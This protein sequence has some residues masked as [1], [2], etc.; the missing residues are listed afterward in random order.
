MARQG[1]K[2]LTLLTL[3]VSINSNAIT[4]DHAAE[5]TTPERTP[6]APAR[7][8]PG[9][10]ISSISSPPCT[11][12]TR[13]YAS[14]FD[15][16][17]DAAAPLLSECALGGL[18]NF[19]VIE[20]FDPFGK[21]LDAIKGAAC[22]IV[23]DIH[24][25]MIAKINSKVSQHNRWVQSVN[26]G[27][28]Q[29]VDRAAREAAAALYDPTTRFTSSAFPGYS[30]EE[31]KEETIVN[32]GLSISDVYQEVTEE[33]ILDS[34]GAITVDDD[35]HEDGTSVIYSNETLGGWQNLY[36]IYNSQ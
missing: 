33:V 34:G 26:S 10:A 23:K 3:V 4:Y 14:Y 24:D 22:K 31:L 35:T 15:D 27:Y 2:L 29:W 8:A 32:T 13:D 25:P 1:V 16:M 18:I 20:G 5:P 12:T 11:S 19:D 9:P 30:D 7:L 6:L 21:I 28:D 36:N 17:F